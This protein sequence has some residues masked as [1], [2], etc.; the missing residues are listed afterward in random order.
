MG[1]DEGFEA[2]QQVDKEQN[3]IQREENQRFRYT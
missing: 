1:E 3:G 2:P